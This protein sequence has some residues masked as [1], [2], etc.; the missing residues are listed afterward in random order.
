MI[1]FF[2]CKKIAKLI[3]DS[4][5]QTLPWQSRLVVRMHLFVCKYCNRFKRQI[6]QLKE[7]IQNAHIENLKPQQKLPLE[8]KQRIQ[9]AIIR[10]MGE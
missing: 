4:H 6:N 10:K 5:D 8:A 3:S 7:L 1:A 9:S 2:S